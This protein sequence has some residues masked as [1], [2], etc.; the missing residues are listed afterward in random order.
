MIT[1]TKG[2]L[3]ALILSGLLAAGPAAAADRITREAA[4]AEVA[5][6]PLFQVLAKHYPKLH[7]QLLDD[8]VRGINAG[9]PYSA[10]TAEIN[11]EIVKLVVEQ[12]PKANVENTIAMLSITRDQASAVLAKDPAFCLSLLGV[13]PYDINA[14]RALPEAL[15]DRERVLMAKLLEQTAV[16]PEAPSATRREKAAQA[17]AIDAY[18]RLSDDRLR[19]ALGEI[20]G[21]PTKAVTPLQQTAFCEFSIA[22]FDQLLKMPP[23]EGAQLFRALTEMN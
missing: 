20:A 6:I 13:R 10:L 19:V 1:K 18:D 2:L 16:A 11:A 17:V 22:M 12:T 21:D 23:V 4:A 9:R 14:T 7:D 8:L 5:A 3:A 15:A